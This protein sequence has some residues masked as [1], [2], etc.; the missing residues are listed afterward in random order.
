MLGTIFTAIGAFRSIAKSPAFRYLLVEVLVI[1]C[2]AGTYIKGRWEGA[3]AKDA[4]YQIVIEEERNRI[5]DINKK[6]LQDAITEI[7]RLKEVVA[8]RNA[9][10]G[11]ILSEAAD[12]MDAARGALSADSVR[13]INRIH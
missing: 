11:F 8:V 12:D 3:A 5:D 1:G 4:Q 10:I 13:R 9:E 7:E 6:A 2:L